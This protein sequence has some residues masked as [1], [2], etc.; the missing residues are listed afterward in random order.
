VLKSLSKQK[1]SANEIT[2]SAA[3]CCSGFL[4]NQ[5]TVMRAIKKTL[6]DFDKD[7]VVKQLEQLI[8]YYEKKRAELPKNERGKSAFCICPSWYVG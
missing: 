7:Y 6:E 8:E 2:V 3:T 4:D 1:Q 5:I